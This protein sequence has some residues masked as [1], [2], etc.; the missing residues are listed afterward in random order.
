MPR[1]K[2]LTFKI[3]DL[4]S[5]QTPFANP[6][7]CRCLAHTFAPYC[8]NLPLLHNNE[9]PFQHQALHLHPVRTSRPT[10]VYNLPSASHKKRRCVKKRTFFFL[11]TKPR[12]SQAEA[13]LLPKDFVSLSIITIIIL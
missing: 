9:K 8:N 13:L 4:N 7:S 5:I 10:R 2:Q 6:A 1:R 11:C 3:R 12:L